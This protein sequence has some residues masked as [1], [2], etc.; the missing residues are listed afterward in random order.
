MADTAGGGGHAFPSR[1]TDMTP[2]FCGS[3]YC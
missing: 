2:N 1:E 3:P